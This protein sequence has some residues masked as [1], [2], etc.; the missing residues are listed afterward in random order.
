MS[1]RNLA[2]GIDLNRDE[3]QICYYNLDT[4]DTV[5]APMKVGNEEVSFRDILDGYER[6]DEVFPEEEA[7]WEARRRRLEEQADIF[8]LLS[9]WLKN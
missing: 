4:G 1:T 2:A 8:I 3:P 7:V 9:P 6:R 5:T